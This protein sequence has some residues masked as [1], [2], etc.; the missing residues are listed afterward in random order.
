MFLSSST[1]EASQVKSASNEKDLSRVAALQKK[2]MEAI[3]DDDDDDVKPSPPGSRRGR[4]RTSDSGTL[5]VPPGIITHLSQ[6]VL[7]PQASRSRLGGEGGSFSRKGLGDRTEASFGMK[8]ANA[9]QNPLV[10]S[11]SEYMAPS[12]PPIP[13]AN[14]AVH[15]FFLREIL[16]TGVS[17]DFR[18]TNHVGGTDAESGPCSNNH[19]Y[20]PQ[21]NW[22]VNDFVAF[23][24]KPATAASHMS[25]IQA[26]VCG[27]L[28][29]P[30][31]S[32]EGKFNG[33]EI[34]EGCPGIHGKSIYGPSTFF[35]SFSYADKFQDLC[36]AIL[37]HY[38]SL[39]ESL[40]AAANGTLAPI[41]YWLS[42]FAV[43]KNHGSDIRKNPDGDPSSAIHRSRAL[44]LACKP[45]FDPAALS[46]AW[47]QFE[48]LVAVNS[49]V[50]IIVLNLE[51]DIS[52]NVV[53]PDGSISV[54][55]EAFTQC[56]SN[57]DIQKASCSNKTDHGWLCS[58]VERQHPG[59]FAQVCPSL[60]NAL[61]P[62]LMGAL[63]T[64][65]LQL[66]HKDYS[67]AIKLIQGDGSKSASNEIVMQWGS[68]FIGG[69]T[70]GGDAAASFFAVALG[71]SHNIIQLHELVLDPEVPPSHPSGSQ[72]LLLT[73]PWN[74]L[75]S[76]EVPTC[77]ISGIGG[78]FK[79]ALS[80]SISGVPGRNQ[81]PG[82]RQATFAREASFTSPS[83]P[84]LAPSPSR[85]LDPSSSPTPQISMRYTRSGTA[86]ASGK[87]GNKSPDPDWTLG[88]WA[89]SLPSTASS[90]WQSPSAP[91]V[92]LPSSWSPA[93]AHKVLKDKNPSMPLTKKQVARAEEEERA[94]ALASHVEVSA[95]GA[96]QLSL[97][98][99]MNPG[100]SLATLSL[101][102]NRLIGG[103]GALTLFRALCSNVS[104]KT[105]LLRDCG[106][107]SSCCKEL[108]KALSMNCSLTCLDLGQN[109]LL[110]QPPPMII[111]TPVSKSRNST[112]GA[113]RPRNSISGASNF[114][115]APVSN[116]MP[117]NPCHLVAWGLPRSQNGLRDL[118]LDSTGLESHGACILVRGLASCTALC[119]LDLSN[120]SIDG[121]MVFP[122]A[123]EFVPD[124]VAAA[125]HA[126][127]MDSEEGIGRVERDIDSFSSPSPHIASHQ[128]HKPSFPAPMASSTISTA[129]D[130]ASL[131]AA[132][133]AGS[134]SLQCLLLSGNKL[135]SEGVVALASA[136]THSS[137]SGRALRMLVL[138]DNDLG[139][140]VGQS[141]GEL[142]QQSSSFPSSSG[143]LVLSCLDISLNPFI[144]DVGIQALAL[145]LKSNSSLIELRAEGVGMGSKG[146]AALAEAIG[147][148]GKAVR[149]VD[150]S[151]NL[152][153]NAGAESF[154]SYS[155]GSSSEGVC[156]L[157]ELMLN[158]CGVGVEGRLAIV[159]AIQANRSCVLKHLSLVGNIDPSADPKAGA[160]LLTMSNSK[161]PAEL[162]ASTLHQPIH[163]NQKNTSS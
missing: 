153:L 42:P 155:L 148:G 71:K 56:L 157:H 120:N 130:C 37:N 36:H 115:F 18:L 112:S 54:A 141:L 14:R 101:S 128:Y 136:L 73:R 34:P 6:R 145:G 109:P 126:M 154:A 20:A 160:K 57:L 1:T 97:A 118:R 132:G 65:I 15:P 82:E 113:A 106:L 79:G 142:L 66:P 99:S 83:L 135:R 92:S 108:G 5:S 70:Q 93:E 147:K 75:M 2:M 74:L 19:R 69:P 129:R 125:Y 17:P 3:I 144:G 7:A 76:Q 30:W 140:E 46:R 150:I 114:K 51:R 12:A 91:H 23:S 61:K 68:A 149:R 13:L 121:K 31:A 45:W 52:L 87:P 152:I 39:P 32:S 139:L 35:V 103:Q 107:D 49:G 24:V 64:L 50:E 48:L 27:S 95:Q 11:S 138:R 163:K 158:R 162:V 104:L 137:R 43:N 8:H 156:K 72:G 26:L 90:T 21:P 111:S 100:G 159:S 98:L 84:V 58:L 67:L 62:A 4:K 146:A 25:F 47:C 55:K 151:D 105:L 122:Y 161:S 22:T 38:A 16:R 131:L 28:S 44:L 96:A 102:H 60:T 124:A 116:D 88:G 40:A 81:E 63:L 41:Y 117:P 77:P 110:L 80:T 133:L 10:L 89:N 53:F 78:G 9:Y 86:G 85:H 119:R 134:R 127:D 123:P 29:L 59:G 143:P 33:Q 94:R